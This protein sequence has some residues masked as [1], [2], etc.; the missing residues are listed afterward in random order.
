MSHRVAVDLPQ[1]IRE[2]L[3]KVVYGPYVS[4]AFLTD[5]STP[6]PVGRRVRHRD[7][8]SGRSTSC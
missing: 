2:A 6:Q 7:A 4:A 3:G 1:D 8:R 5:E